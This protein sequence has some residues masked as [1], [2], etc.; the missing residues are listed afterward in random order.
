MLRNANQV[1]WSERQRRFLDADRQNPIVARAARLATVH[2]ANV[3]P[4]QAN[5][6]FSEA[7]RAPADEFSRARAEAERLAGVLRRTSDAR[8]AAR[9]GGSR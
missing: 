6:A 9:I 8:S 4:W 7:M 3:C 2:R 5:P 1:N